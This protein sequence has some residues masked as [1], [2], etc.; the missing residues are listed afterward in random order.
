MNKVLDYTPISEE[1]SNLKDNYPMKMLDNNSK[2]NQRK[3]LM[4]YIG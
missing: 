4:K 2:K 1:D 3:N